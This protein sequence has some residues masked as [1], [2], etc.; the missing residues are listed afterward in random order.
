[1]PN[2]WLI[3]GVLIAVLTLNV[4]RAA[5]ATDNQDIPY[6]IGRVNSAGYK[7]LSH[8]TGF[9]S[10]GG[11]LVTAAHCIP[12]KSDEIVHFLQGYT[13]SKSKAHYQINSEEFDIFKDRDIAIKC[14][15]SSLEFGIPQNTDNIS[16]KTPVFIYGYA[17]PAKHK[18]SQ[19]KCHIVKNIGKHNIL[20]NCPAA[21]GMSGGPVLI[22]KKGVWKSVAVISTS[23]SS[24]T[25]AAALDDKAIEEVCR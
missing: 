13:R 4:E 16:A 24:N 25:V 1:L 23:S 18:L 21:K 12:S 3:W 2:N 22:L 15:L 19:K 7:T 6:M 9:L 17:I 5:F 11:H 10:R 14:G 20:L 8:C